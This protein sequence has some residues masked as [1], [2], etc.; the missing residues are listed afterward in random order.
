MCTRPIS[1]IQIMGEHMII[2]IFSVQV[3][4]G[5]EAEFE[6]KYKSISVPFMQSCE[7]MQEVR[8]GRPFES[9]VGRYV[10]V[11]YWVSQEHLE[12]A[13]GD[14]WREAHIPAGME[15]YISSCGVEHF[16]EM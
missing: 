2:R 11:S 13:L 1:A 9:A 15:N 12:A 7:G 8:I 14:K 3:K 10:M 6:E 5:L 4:E 16:E